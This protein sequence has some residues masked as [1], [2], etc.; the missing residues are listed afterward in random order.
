[1]DCAVKYHSSRYNT[2]YLTAFNLL[3]NL[4]LVCVFMV[5]YSFNCIHIL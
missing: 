1:M 4:E 3:N 5:I 2:V